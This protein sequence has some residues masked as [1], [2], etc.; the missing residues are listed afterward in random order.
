[1]SVLHNLY[2]F[3]NPRLFVGLGP[4]PVSHALKLKSLERAL[5]T[6]RWQALPDYHLTLR[7]VG[8]VEHRVADDLLQA[9]QTVRFEPFDL[10][11]QGVDTFHKNGHPKIVWAG[12]EDSKPLRTLQAQVAEVVEKA[13][14]HPSENHFNPHIT[15]ARVK[16]DS[17][18]LRSFLSEY[19]GFKLPPFT[20]HHFC[21]YLRREDANTGRGLYMPLGLFPVEG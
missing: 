9:L 2:E 1:M 12:V 13:T 3:D 5:P 6:A 20:V 15:L 11:I 17:V 14:G 21:L 16:E 7:F 18:P 4:L 19:K 8:N 10:T